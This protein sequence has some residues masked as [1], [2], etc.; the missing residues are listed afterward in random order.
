MVKI[1]VGP[2]GDGVVDVNSE[3][4]S[5]SSRAIRTGRRR[6]GGEDIHNLAQHRD[7]AGLVDAVVDHVAGAAR[8]GEEGLSIQGQA[9]LKFEYCMDRFARRKL[10]H[11]ALRGDDQHL[12]IP[13]SSQT[14]QGRKPPPHDVARGRGPIVGEAIPGRQDDDVQPGVKPRERTADLLGTARA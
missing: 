14:T 10:L 1:A 7:L 12:A 9:R 13:P 4:T 8:E 6:V 2:L 5:A 11:E 3:I